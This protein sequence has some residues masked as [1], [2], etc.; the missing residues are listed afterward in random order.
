[1]PLV[2]VC[3]S[4]SNQPLNPGLVDFFLPIADNGTV[5]FLAKRR[6]EKNWWQ[7]AMGL[8]FVTVELD[9]TRSNR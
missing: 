4:G 2:N 3:F 9:D 1:V 5:D 7:V 8:N 6:T